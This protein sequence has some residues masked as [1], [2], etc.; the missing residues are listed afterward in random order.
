M[1]ENNCDYLKTEKKK[2][3]KSQTMR[4]K[5]ESE[6]AGSFLGRVVAFLLTCK[7][8]KKKPNPLDYATLLLKE[9]NGNQFNRPIYL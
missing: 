7:M 9:E 3:N 6:S 1:Q 8:F 4:G 5:G 2:K